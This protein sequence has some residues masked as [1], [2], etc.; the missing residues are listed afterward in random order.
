MKTYSELIKLKTF[1]ERFEYLKIGGRVGDLTFG[2]NRYINQRL[3]HS[4]R[5]AHFKDEMRIRDN[6]C[7]LGILDRVIDGYVPTIGSDGKKKVEE[8]I[9]L[10][11]INPITDEDILFEHPSVFDPENV[12]CCSRATH[13]AI[14]YGDYSLLEG[15]ELIE[16]FP[17]DTIPWRTNR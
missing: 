8:P 2:P 11:H 14:H 17:N 3:Y 16:R 12:I 10:H 15:Y 4:I 7:D 6:G 13:Q 5:W 9:Y 1:R